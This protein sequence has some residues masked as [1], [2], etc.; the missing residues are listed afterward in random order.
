MRRIT[1]HSQNLYCL[2]LSVHPLT[3]YY[4][5]FEFTSSI[6]RLVVFRLNREKSIKLIV[7][8][9]FLTLNWFKKKFATLT[10]VGFL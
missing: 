10:F 2:K 1:I 5:W 4:T 8:N 9:D 3:R 6:L 7:A